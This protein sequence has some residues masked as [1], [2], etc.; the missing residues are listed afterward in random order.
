M[1]IYE[2]QCECGHRFERLCKMNDNPFSSCPE[3]GGEGHRVMSAFRTGR[4]SSGG[5]ESFSSGSGC[6]SCSSS[7][8]SSCH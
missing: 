6:G 3:C 1:P 8:C 5:S 2:F 4:S 7:S